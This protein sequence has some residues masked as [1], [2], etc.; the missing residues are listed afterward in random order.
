MKDG[1][2]G[3]QQTTMTAAISACLEIVSTSSGMLKIRNPR[4]KETN[5]RPQ[6]HWSI[7]PYTILVHYL[8]YAVT[9]PHDTRNTSTSMSLA[10]ANTKS[11]YILT[12]RLSRT[13]RLPS[14]FSLEKGEDFGSLSE[15][16]PIS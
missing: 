5:L 9:K 13:L 15:A 3:E 2:V 8:L 6:H 7:D 16:T 1:N 12:I 4:A 14:P 11:F 10:M